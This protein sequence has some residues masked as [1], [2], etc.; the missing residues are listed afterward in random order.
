MK[1][2]LLKISFTLTLALV[3]VSFTGCSL[4]PGSDN[5]SVS[6]GTQ[7]VLKSVDGG[8]TWERK[9]QIEGSETGL[10]ALKMGAL[11]MAMDNRQVLYLGTLGG[12]I[13]KS[14]NGGDTWIKLTDGG[15]FFQE[16]ASVY[17]VA[18]ESENVVYVATLNENRGV[19]FKSEDGG[20]HWCPVYISSEADKP[21]NKVKIDPHNKFTVY[22]G[23]GQG[24]LLRSDDAGGNWRPLG[25]FQEGVKDFAVDYANSDRILV[26]TKDGVYRT[27]DGG[28]AGAGSWKNINSAVR[29]ASSDTSWE[30]SRMT[31]LTS[32]NANPATAYINLS[33]LVIVTRDGGGTWALL[34]T[35]TP[36]L[37]ALKTIP[38]VRSLGLVG[39]TIYYGA[40]NALY[41]SD[42]KGAT[43]S[44]TGIPIQ[45]D[46]RY[47]VSDPVNAQVIYVAG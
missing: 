8:K 26:I 38:Q 11:G 12:G 44:S 16:K 18:V 22:V 1:G 6:R 3:A 7:G 47:T 37:T 42:N 39:D 5:V 9:T 40:G 15:K 20:K 19:L 27:Q 35:I 17:D 25:W 21:I 4:L 33:N 13:Y 14:Q 34:P 32:D 28:R 46:V 23:T 10:E 24:G 41:R 36:A 43:W 29:L 2:V 45:G 31:S 30:F